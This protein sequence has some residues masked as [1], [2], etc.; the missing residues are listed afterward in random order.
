M[1]TIY[2]FVVL[3]MSAGVGGRQ[4][5][6]VLQ[7]SCVFCSCSVCTNQSESCGLRECTVIYPFSHC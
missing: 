6:C 2:G 5:P 1:S 7:V 4:G 3:P